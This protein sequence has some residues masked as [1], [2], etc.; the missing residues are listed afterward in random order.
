M[1]FTYILGIILIFI[2]STAASCGS[3]RA[4]QSVEAPFAGGIDGITGGFY[5]LVGPFQQVR[6]V[7]VTQAFC[8]GSR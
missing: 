3:N 1:R 8:F 4:E 5:Q 2:M 7:G 6:G